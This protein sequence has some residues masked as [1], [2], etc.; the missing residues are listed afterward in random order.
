MKDKLTYL[1]WISVLNFKFNKRRNLRKRGK[2]LRIIKTKSTH[3]CRLS[4][5]C[6]IAI[7]F[8][9]LLSSQLTKMK[10]NC[11]GYLLTFNLEVCKLLAKLSIFFENVNKIIKFLLLKVKLHPKKKFQR[12]VKFNKH[13]KQLWC[14]R[15][16]TFTVYIKI[17]L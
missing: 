5:L 6:F 4:Q 1:C 9:G 10:S 14:K 16:A 12:L 13:S 17:M 15:N 7:M 2:T 3:H 8:N 11:S